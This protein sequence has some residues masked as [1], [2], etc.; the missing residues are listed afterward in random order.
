MNAQRHAP[1]ASAA[2]LGPV[3]L[4]LLGPLEALVGGE[5]ASLGPPK[6]RAL[7]AH[8]LLKANEAVPVERLVDALWPEE[9]PASARHAIQVYVSALR[10]ALGDP[11]RIEAR[12]RSYVLRADREE[13]DLGRFRRLVAE[14]QEAVAAEDA[15]GAAERLDEALALWRGR[16]LVDLDGEP[17]VRELVLDLA[18]ERVAAIELRIASKLEAGQSAELVPELER[19]IAEHPARE[20]LHAD[21]MLALYRAGRK[22]DAQ[23]AYRRAEEALLSELGIAPSTRLAELAAAIRRDDPALT[24]EPPELRARRHL[25]AQPNQF[26]GRERELDE[27]VALVVARGQRLLTLT[28]TGGIGKTRLA[29]AAAHRLV[30]DFADG[31]WFVDLSA[32]TDP[33]DVPLAVAQAL[34]VVESHEDPLQTALESH[35]AEKQLL[36]VVDNFE[37]VAEATPL[38]VALLEAAPRLTLLVTSRVSLH[39]SGDV[40]Y[41]V[42]PLAL[43]DPAAAAGPGSLAA[44][45]SVRLFVARGRAASRRFELAEQN[46]GDVAE[47]CVS[48]DGLPLAIEL[49]GAALRRF[50][51]SELR[52]ELTRS[53]HVL[54]GGPV[55]AP[56]RQ[57]TVRATIEWSYGMLDPAEQELF[58]RLSV[59]AGGWTQD[60]ARDVCGA[61]ESELAS[62]RAQG[63]IQ[64]SGARFAMLATIREFAAEQ[65]APDDAQALARAHAEFFAGQAEAY[66]A[67]AHATGRGNLELLDEVGRDYE[68]F[69][70]ALRSSRDS[71]EAMLL[72]RLADGLHQYWQLRG[73]FQEAR[74]WLETA[75]EAPVEDELLRARVAYSVAVI[76]MQQGDYMRQRELLEG[77]LQVF[78]RLGDKDLEMS[79]LGDLGIAY[80]WL[81]EYAE[82]REHLTASHSLARELGDELRLARLANIVGVVALFEERFVEAEH[83]CEESLDTCRRIGDREGSAFALTNLAHVDL[84]TGRPELAAARYR[85]S[86]LLADELQFPHQVAQCM[87]GLAFVAR[88]AGDLERSASLLGA[89]DSIRAEIGAELSPYDGPKVESAWVAIREGLGEEAATEAYEAG[90]SQPSDEALAYA[91]RA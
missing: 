24:L 79:C 54:V 18:E 28:G 1:Q 12:S 87:L 25:P 17:G 10:R 50:S 71:G 13:T 29:L 39:L 26:I 16:A 59:F 6:Q 42:H 9:P 61:G 7:L 4:R 57:Q 34:G 53:L 60:A 22:T 23:E 85:E 19:L 74:E 33:A 88:R 48:L 90:R 5:A 91:S 83:W 20:Q 73:P 64:A 36:L 43:P 70:A 56:A 47:I 76:C 66:Q 37:H 30:P 58:A 40:E 63:L 41:N 84:E 15:A 38:L 21:L 86:M 8:L 81:G 49:A 51:P 80:S 31:V 14:A 78:R 82:A 27:I 46:A 32:L 35:F 55:D 11:R 2:G 67:R 72:A 89:S 65:L 44:F 69:R 68:N 52:A 75:L 77:A 3:E 62:L 45:E